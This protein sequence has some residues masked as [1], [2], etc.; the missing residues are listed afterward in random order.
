MSAAK[1]RPRT[2]PPEARRDELMTAALDLFLE[3][4]V[5][6]TTIEQITSGA[7]VAKGTFY[8]HF[9]SKEDLLAALGQRFARE[10]LARIEGEISKQADEDWVGKLS[11]WARAG[12][13]GYLDSIRLHDI[14]FHEHRPPTRQGMVDNSIINHLRDLL[15]AGGRAGVWSVEDPHFTAVFLF[16]GLHGVVDE[17]HIKGSPIDRDRL[18]DGLE[19]LCF[20]T[21]GLTRNDP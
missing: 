1:P 9:S 8:L 4:G 13:G 16:S 10:L 19:Q 20:R 6:P 21:V 11:A 18:A 2:K 17:A 7:D 3:Q 14:A 12:V 15:Q 5:G